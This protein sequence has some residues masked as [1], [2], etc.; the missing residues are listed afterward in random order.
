MSNAIVAAPILEYSPLL[1]DADLIEIIACA[2]VQRGPGRHRAPQAGERD[3][4]RPAGQSLDMP[5][6]A[7]LLVNPDA[8]IRKE[9]LDRIMEQAE[10]ISAW[11]MPLALRADLSARAIRRIGSFVGASHPGAAGGAQRSLRCHPPPSEPR[12][13]AGWRE[14]R[15][16]SRQR[17]RRADGRPGKKAGQ[18]DGAFVEQ[19][20]QADSASWWS[21]A[22]AALAHVPNR[23]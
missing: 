9:T 12:V 22:L 1:S 3:R 14:P 2:Q 10:E 4:E 5:A 15:D 6:V 17:A 11:H 20:A 13:R 16:G 7:A 8:Q 18:L 21:Q 19:A 23:R